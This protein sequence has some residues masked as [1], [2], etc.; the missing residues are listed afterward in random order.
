MRIPDEASDQRNKNA[1]YGHDDVDEVVL[2]R[3]EAR[4][5]PETEE[6]GGAELL[7]GDVVGDDVV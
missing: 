3:P 1:Y 4:S 5:E 6:L 7:V 2:G